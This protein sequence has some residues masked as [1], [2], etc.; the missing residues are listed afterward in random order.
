M[1][2]TRAVTTSA[3]LCARLFKAGA[4]VLATLIVAPIVAPIFA[5]CSSDQ[6]RDQWYNTD[7]GLTYSPPEVGATA[8]DGS[9][10]ALDTA[11]DAAADV[12]DGNSQTPDSSTNTGDDGATERF[13]D[14][15]AS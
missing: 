10:D 6:R 12:F 8:A 7:V 5:A 13:Q 11:P 2:L 1:P 15:D 14:S 9:A 3:R 4:V